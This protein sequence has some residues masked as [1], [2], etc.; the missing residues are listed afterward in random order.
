[1]NASRPPADA[2]T[3][4]IGKR[5]TVSAGEGFFFFAISADSDRRTN[6]VFAGR[7]SSLQLQHESALCFAQ[8]AS[9]LAVSLPHMDAPLDVLIIEDD[10][11][12][13]RLLK[14]IVER[15]G[16][17]CE[18]AGD[19]DDGLTAIRRRSPKVIILDLLLPNVTGF[20]VLRHL[21]EHSPHFLGRT[22]IVT[23]AAESRY[24]SCREIPLTRCVMRKP[25]D[26]DLL[27]AEI[28]GCHENA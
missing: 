21:H 13:Q 14:H 18:C 2:P 25:I 4:T 22:I 26:I 12:I 3:P 11:P 6:V 23:A 17:D 15:I 7:R 19:G 1:M 24:A 8:R 10:M 16:F 5:L 27:S 28:T 20:D 9:T